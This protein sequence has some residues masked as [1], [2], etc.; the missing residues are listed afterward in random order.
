MLTF[1]TTQ[2]LHHH[3]HGCLNIGFN[4]GAGVNGGGDSVLE[5]HKPCSW[6]MRRTASET[7]VL[8]VL[9]KQLNNT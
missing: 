7:I 5:K 1:K 4:R 6:P 8:C 2:D 9:F 3:Q